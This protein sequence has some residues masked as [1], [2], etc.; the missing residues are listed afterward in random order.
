MTTRSASHDDARD[1]LPPHLRE[2]FEP[3]V[4]EYKFLA[5]VHHGRSYVSYVVLADLIR[6]GW[7]PSAEA[8]PQVSA[9]EADSDLPS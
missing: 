4:A 7:R 1:S 5:G 9:P 6:S 3:L 8:L 2:V